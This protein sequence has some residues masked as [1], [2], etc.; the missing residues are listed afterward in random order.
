MGE[1]EGMGQVREVHSERKDSISSMLKE[2]LKLVR[3]SCVR[4]T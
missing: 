3:K 4:V 2:W 1:D